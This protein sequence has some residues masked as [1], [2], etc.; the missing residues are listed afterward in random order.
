MLP[1]KFDLTSLWRRAASRVASQSTLDRL[2]A[3]GNAK[4]KPPARVFWTR[5][6]YL[7]HWVSAGVSLAGMLV[8]AITGITL[9]HAADIPGKPKIVTVESVVPDAIVAKISAPAEKESRPLP[10]D[11]RDWVKEE[12]SLDVGGRQAEWSADEIYLA[13]PRPGGDAWLSIDL[14]SGDAL[15]EKT[16][17]GWVS[18][19][20]DLHKGRNTGPAWSWFIDIFAVACVLFCVTGLILLQQHAGKRPSTWP[21]VAAGV[22]L[23]LLLIVFF[24]H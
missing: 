17:R 9:N 24:V 12:M 18:Y 1:V 16:T 4:P 5:Q 19:L 23:P 22:I 2:Q 6:L 8:F 14:A 7:W 21:V 3:N 15:Y 20:N 13:L 10:A 11:L